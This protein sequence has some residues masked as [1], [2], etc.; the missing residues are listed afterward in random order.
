MGLRLNEYMAALSPSCEPSGH[1]TGHPRSGFVLTRALIF[2]VQ[3]ES[4]QSWEP[5]SPSQVEAVSWCPGSSSRGDT[6]KGEKPASTTGSRDFAPH[7]GPG[8]PS[9]V[10]PSPESLSPARAWL[11]APRGALRPLQ[12]G[13][14]VQDVRSVWT[15]SPAS[16][17]RPGG[18]PDV[19]SCG[20][21]PGPRGTSWR[22]GQGD[23]R[24]AASWWGCWGHRTGPRGAGFPTSHPPT[25]G[26]CSS[27]RC[28]RSA[29]PPPPRAGLSPF[30]GSYCAE[31]P[32][33][34]PENV[35][36]SG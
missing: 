11:C 12:P 1:V 5:L 14:G 19:W 29:V 35:M 2:L 26:L 23:L 24:G 4:P 8:S 31:G 27:G 18:G 10:A 33:L 13:W 36:A 20:R 9:S 21:P 32:P 28:S 25:P 16:F 22:A 34:S 30:A 6:R 7:T 3:H 15:C 17:R